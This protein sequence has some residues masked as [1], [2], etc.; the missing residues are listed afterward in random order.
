[1]HFAQAALYEYE[2][3][4]IPTPFCKYGD[5]YDQRF[6]QGEPSHHVLLVT[7]T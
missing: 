3:S 6:I 2:E 4:L 1:M 5:W 7:R